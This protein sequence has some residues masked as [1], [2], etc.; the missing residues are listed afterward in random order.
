MNLKLNGR[1]GIVFLLG[2]IGN[3]EKASKPLFCF[4]LHP[5]ILYQQKYISTIFSDRMQ[6]VYRV[7]WKPTNEQNEIELNRIVSN[8]LKSNYLLFLFSLEIFIS[9]FMNQAF[10]PN[11][12]CPIKNICNV[13]IHFI[14]LF[15]KDKHLWT[16]FV[17]D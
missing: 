10:V 3:V 8:G 1:N 4:K 17:S 7:Q 13:E 12:T 15:S 2:I 6:I 14:D 9:L 5:S 16:H 11:F